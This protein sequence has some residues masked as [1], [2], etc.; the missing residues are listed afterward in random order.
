MSKYKIQALKY[1]FFTCH[2][3]Y[4]VHILLLDSVYKY[5]Y[6]MKYHHFIKEV[7]LRFTKE[8]LRST[9]DSKNR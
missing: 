2:R 1:D 3:A 5:H 4:S 7:F 8:F 9:S 6:H